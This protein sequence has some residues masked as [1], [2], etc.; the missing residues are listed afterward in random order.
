M[1]ARIF[2]IDGLP[3]ALTETHVETALNTGF[4]VYC[5]VGLPTDIIAPVRELLQFDSRMEFE[6]TFR[7]RHSDNSVFLSRYESDIYVN[8]LTQIEWEGWQ[9]AIKLA[10]GE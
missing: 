8:S 1:T 2:A 9:A 3:D 4:E 7:L 5:N 10:R 6:K